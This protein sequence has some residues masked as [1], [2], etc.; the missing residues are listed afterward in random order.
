MHASRLSKYKQFSATRQKAL[1]V[2]PKMDFVC[3]SP[4][5]S[6]RNGRLHRSPAKSSGIV[7]TPG[8][9]IGPM[10]TTHAFWK[11]MQL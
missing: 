10:F 8:Y 7:K 4:V 3:R 1:V 9:E 6:N 11:V 2:W 5:S